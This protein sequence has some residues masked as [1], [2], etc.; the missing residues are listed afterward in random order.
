MRVD[1][2]VDPVIFR[3]V[4]SPFLKAAPLHNIAILTMIEGRTAA[5]PQAVASDHYLAVIDAD[6]RVRGAVVVTAGG[7]Y[8]GDLRGDLVVPVARTV[9][10]LA[11]GTPLVEGVPP[12]AQAFAREWSEL[13]GR[14]HREVVSK[15]L[16]RLGRFC[17]Q[18]APGAARVADPA[19]AELCASW[20]CAFDIDVG[21]PAS[22]RR[23]GVEQA[24]RGRRRWLWE[25]DGKPVSMVGHTPTVAGV[26]RVGPVYTP[27]AHRGH[28]YASALTTY[29]T[30][31]L[32]D[33]G[34]DVCLYTD[35]ANPTSNKIYA[36]IGYQPVADLVRIRFD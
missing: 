21:E 12:V 32:L 11:P 7:C 8:L 13:T 23:P 14:P 6:G 25:L 36:Q 16:H 20:D 35:L 5:A 3:D 22:N 18:I 19:D 33:H 27:D 30:K 10:D 34:F 2:L 26:A 4:V 29:V 28:G 15:R 31:R 1:V 24:I 17:P 9:A